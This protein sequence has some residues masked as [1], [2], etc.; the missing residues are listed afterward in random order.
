MG[1]R[2]SSRDINMNYSYELK[3]DSLRTH[4][5]NE[6][7]FIVCEIPNQWSFNALASHSV[8]FVISQ[9]N[10]LNFKN[11][12]LERMYKWLEINHPELLI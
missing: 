12:Y 1:I 4:D 3:Y 9:K 6:K 5:A 10:E 8:D 2:K 11:S 7:K